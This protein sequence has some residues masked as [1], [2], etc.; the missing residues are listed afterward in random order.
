MEQVV[1]LGRT[2]DEP[3]AGRYRLDRLISRGGMGDV[4]E[5]TDERLQRQV[6]VKVF[7][8]E[9]SGDRLRFDSE[10]ELL[11]SLDHPGLV[12]VFDAGEHDRA[13]FVVLELVDG[14]TLASRLVDGALP[15]DEVAQLGIAVSDALAY[16]HAHGVVHRDVKPSNVL[17]DPMGQPRLVDFGIARVV[18][19]TRV[20]AAA[21]AVGTA[22]YMAPEQVEGHDVSGAADVY[23]LGLVLLE[24]L[25]GQRAF[26]GTVHEVAVARLTRSPDV[27]AAPAPWRELLGAM[28]ERAPENRPSAAEVNRRL[29]SLTAPG[30]RDDDGSPVVPSAVVPAPASTPS[31][32]ADAPTQVLDDSTSRTDVLPLVLAPAP[33][34][35]RRAFAGLGGL[36]GTLW[37]RRWV[38]A[39]VVVLLGVVLWAAIA[40]GGD[41]L[42]V[43]PTSTVPVT[44]ATVAP[45][46]T[47]APTTSEAP[48][49][50]ERKGPGAGKKE[51]GGDEGPGGRDD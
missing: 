11:A 32:G 39:V 51:K 25:T 6:A 37:A 9:P 7:R 10:V 14:P 50:A 34:P 20:T 33:S 3:L 42:E 27:Q 22:A 1:A 40:A 17:C 23:S 5:A 13:A 18:D 8:A 41:G 21:T 31:S 28:T 44:E 48:E 30:A 47:A 12:R 26:Q 4:F 29:V 43:P 38:L 35:A 45:T 15:P 24:L 36:G 2:V 19:T 49:P 16:I 46:T